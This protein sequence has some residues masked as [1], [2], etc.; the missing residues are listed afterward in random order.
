MNL[1]GYLEL[2]GYQVQGL[3]GPTKGRFLTTPHLC[4]QDC[5][6]VGFLCDLQSSQPEAPLIRIHD[7]LQSPGGELAV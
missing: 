3:R 4:L 1:G 2:L 6:P 7:V 5:F